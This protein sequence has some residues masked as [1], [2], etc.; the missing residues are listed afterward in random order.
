M[1]GAPPDAVRLT[2]K[3]VRDLPTPSTG[4]D[5]EQRGRVLIIGGSEVVPGAALLAAVAALRA[6]AGKLQIA[7]ARGVATGLAIAAPEA[8]VMALE[9]DQHGEIARSCAALDHALGN[10]DAVLV[11][12]G[13]RRSA[14]TA[15]LVHHIAGR[16]ASTLVLDAGALSAELCAPPGSP[17]ILTP[18]A[19]E[20]AAM[21]EVEK[22]LVLHEPQTFA[23]E[24][25]RRMRSVLVL[26]GATTF[27][28]SPEGA[29]WVHRGGCPGL[30]TSGSGD[31]LAGLI[32]GL[33]ARGGTPLQA[34]LGGVLVHAKAGK[35]LSRRI[36]TVGFLAREIPDQVP[37]IL[38]R[39]A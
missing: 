25:A 38:E 39:L 18:H 30:G 34:A 1:T 27:I 37:G 21:A 36:G 33:G 8:L 19:G 7:T 32:A 15:A 3:V 11:G 17:F 28:A 31:V 23:R 29:L 26:K 10:A 6:G 12:S 16:I 5:K 2:A 22:A 35:R 24:F 4:D 9:V 20:M 13:M 14:A